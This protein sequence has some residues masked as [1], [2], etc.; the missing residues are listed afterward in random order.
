M[1]VRRRGARKHK[2]RLSAFSSGNHIVRLGI[3]VLGFPD[4]SG[5]TVQP[6]F[7]GQAPDDFLKPTS[8]RLWSMRKIAFKNLRKI[9]IK[10]TREK[11]HRL[12]TSPQ[13]PLTFVNPVGLFCLLFNSTQQ[14][15]MRMT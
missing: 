9:V 12:P 8:W 13:S 1:A 14:D 10:M 3:G 5:V 6:W 4:A 11:S 2:V 15:K 7:D